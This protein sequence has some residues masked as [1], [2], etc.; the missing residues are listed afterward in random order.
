[1]LRAAPA[2]GP[3]PAIALVL[4]LKNRA[5]IRPRG[6][7]FNFVPDLRYSQPTSVIKKYRPPHPSRYERRLFPPEQSSKT[8]SLLNELLANGNK[9]S[10]WR[11][12][13]PWRPTSAEAL[14]FHIFQSR[15]SL[16]VT[17]FLDQKRVPPVTL[18]QVKRAGCSPL[19]MLR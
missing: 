5:L 12:C 14:A 4:S 1:M 3:A 2:T 7:V 17:Q 16:L 8:S 19:R 10:L 13:R 6:A 15:A 11:R 9:F 18:E